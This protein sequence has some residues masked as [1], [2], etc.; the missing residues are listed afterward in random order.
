MRKITEYLRLILFV[1]GV[2]MG[3]QV[4]GFVDQYGKSLQSRLVESQHSL[5]E[6][7]QDADKFFG[8]DIQQLVAH[9]Q[10]Q[11]DPVFNAGA[12]SIQAIYSR[13]S[14]LSTALN[15]F[16]QSFYNAYSQVFISPIDDI[17]SHVWQH[18]TYNIMLNGSAITV[19]LL[20]GLL[21]AM[22]IETLLHLLI[23]LLK[24]ST[25]K[26]RVTRKAID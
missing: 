6:F 12:K 22:C 23:L 25:K 4:P 7:Q 1:T 21:F 13:M 26:L 15:Q 10:Q 9:Y 19:G 5:R 14:L 18:Y 8:G 3:I 17:R 24:T 16:N 11:K 2:L 20:M